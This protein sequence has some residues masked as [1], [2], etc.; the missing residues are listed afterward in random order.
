MRPFLFGL[1]LTLVGAPAFA[2]VALVSPGSRYGRDVL[3]VG[4]CGVAGGERTDRVYGFRPGET[5]TVVFDEY[6]DHPGH[7]RISFDADGD[8]DFVVPASFDDLDTAPSVLL[9]GI[10]DRTGGGTYEVQVTLPD[11]ECE[12]CTLQV[13]QVMTDKPPY[14]DGNDI[15]YQCSDLVLTRGEL[16]PPPPGLEADDAGGCTCDAAPG[17]AALVVALLVITRRRRT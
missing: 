7:F 5:I 16:P 8:D 2:H 6:I 13:I 14:G 15:Y 9:D 4:P 11:L 3:K 17:T 10:A 12:R 1:C